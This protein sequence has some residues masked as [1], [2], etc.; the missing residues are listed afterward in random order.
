MLLSDYQSDN[1]YF[2]ICLNLFYVILCDYQIDD[3][4]FSIS[5]N[6]LDVT[7]RLTICT[8]LMF[9]F[10]D[11]FYMIIRLTTYTILY[12]KHYYT[13]YIVDYQI[14]NDI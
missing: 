8:L 1:I 14:D 10:S 11:L 9:Y 3:M 6:L 7:I 12:L 4:H 5:R 13:D 2:S